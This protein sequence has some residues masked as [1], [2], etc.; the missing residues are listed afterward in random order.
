MPFQVETQLFRGPLDL[1]VHLIRRHEI[2]VAEVPLRV[3][4]DQFVEFLS[5]QAE[6][7][8]E[9]AGDFLEAAGRLIEW[10]SR[11]LLPTEESGEESDEDPI[12]EVGR[13]L[14]R[15]LL[16][17]KQYREAAAQLSERASAWQTRF[18]RREPPS[19][20]VSD[21]SQEPIREIELWDLVSAFGRLAQDHVP[22][23]TEEVVAEAPPLH[24]VIEEV[25]EQLRSESR[26]AFSQLA[27]AAATR[28][29]LVALVLA[30]LELIRRGRAKVEQ[31]EQ[32]G[33]I[34]VLERSA[35]EQA[36]DA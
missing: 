12:E 36:T 2:D 30:V 5:A 18:A 16:E 33:E 20:A 34:W 22:E 24:T 3:V 9:A 8:V 13:D 4:V 25:A 23:L 10:K 26:L 32:F 19:V 35:E 11:R 1:L 17:F 31:A 29:R 14:V 7:D 28:R 15:R 21:P 6:A 27:A